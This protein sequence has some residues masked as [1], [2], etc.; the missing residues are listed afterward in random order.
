MAADLVEARTM[1]T[2]P[3][4]TYSHL[5]LHCFDLDKMAD[6]YKSVMGLTETDQGTLN[7]P[8]VDVRIIFLSGDPRD[9]H[10]IALAEGRTAEAG[11]LLINQISFR[12][13]GLDTLRALK[14]K[15]DDL[16]MPIQRIT[17]HCISWS[18]YFHDPEG[19]RIEAFVDAPFFVNQPII[20]PLDL[21]LTNEEIVAA[22]EARFKDY[23]SFK[24]LADWRSEFTKDLGLNA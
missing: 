6:F 12:L 4:I 15:I 20:E 22:T 11:S 7:L 18:I 19:N 5:G 9:H 3:S 24:Q 1:T 10:Q 8:G 23:P 17:D 2:A 13:D 14:D 21:S 16:G